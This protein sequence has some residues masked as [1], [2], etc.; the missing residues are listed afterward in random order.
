MDRVIKINWELISSDK[1]LKKTILDWCEKNSEFDIERR[2]I[3]RL[4]DRHSLKPK[5]IHTDEQCS[6]YML[7]VQ[8]PGKDFYGI[9]THWNL[10]FGFS[11]CGHLILFETNRI[12]N[13]LTPQFYDNFLKK[14]LECSIAH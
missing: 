11:D 14:D 3:L 7:E 13:Q 1:E 6:L 5:T 4:L 8:L 2:D 9:D 10:T 12:Y